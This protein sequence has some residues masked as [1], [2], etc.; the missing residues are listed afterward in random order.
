LTAPK[1]GEHVAYAA[2]QNLF[3][4]RVLIIKNLEK[5]L[6]PPQPKMRQ[7]LSPREIQIRRID[8]AIRFLKAQHRLLMARIRRSTS[9]SGFA[10]MD[11][12]AISPNRSSMLIRRLDHPF[13]FQPMNNELL[14]LCANQILQIPEIFGLR[15][16]PQNCVDQSTSGQF[17]IIT[18]HFE[19]FVVQLRTLNSDC[20]TKSGTSQSKKLALDISELAG[21]CNVV[22]STDGE[23]K[24]ARHA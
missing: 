15:K 1:K 10:G 20:D 22:S 12:D 18:P 5:S 4:F 23:I 19:D 11:W 21:T 13:N 3:R 6:N 16:Y 7:H 2:T 8:A 14:A 24:R 17:N 9:N